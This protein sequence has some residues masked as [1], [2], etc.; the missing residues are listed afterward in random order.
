MC[1]LA[2]FNVFKMFQYA[3]QTQ[4]ELKTDAA[5]ERLKPSI[6]QRQD[7]EPEIPGELRNQ[8]IQLGR[9]GG[10]TLVSLNCY[11]CLPHI[12]RFL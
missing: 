12:S 4:E 3:E 11:C 10:Q 5:Q 2:L 6:V 8:E 9:T 1:L 7:R